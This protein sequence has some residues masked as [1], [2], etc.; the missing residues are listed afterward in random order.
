MTIE[1]VTPN[2]VI[3]QRVRAAIAKKIKELSF[4]MKLQ[5]LR[6]KLADFLYNK[7]ITSEI[8]ASLS[9]GILRAE[10][11]LDDYE[12]SNLNNVVIDIIA[13][14][15]R[16]ETSNGAIKIIINFIDDDFDANKTGTY[17][18]TNRKGESIKIDWLRWLLF[19]GINTVVPKSAIYLKPGRGRSEMAIMITPKSGGSY[20]VDEQFSGTDVD[21]WITRM[22]KWNK[23]EIIKIIKDTLDAA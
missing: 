5:K 6:D 19:E 15:T 20:S 22:V 21:N 9:G 13:L 11:G 4:E 10:F 14:T 3:S 8:Y 16:I 12:V 2:G 17:L 1:I 7:C 23:A 18:Y